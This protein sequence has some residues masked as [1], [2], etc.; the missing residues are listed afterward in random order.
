MKV[1]ILGGNAAGMSA[2]GRLKRKDPSVE[3]TVI[4]KT[5]EVSY[6]A[7]GLPFYVG[8]I[9]D[10]LDLM[11]IRKPEAFLAQ[12]IDLRLCEQAQAVD[13]SS[14]QVTIGKHGGSY[15]QAYDRL[16]IATGSSAIVPRIPGSTLE[17][18]YTLKTL[19]D[20]AA[21]KEALNKREA[22]RVVIIGGGYIGLE[23]AEACLRL[24][25][26]VCILEALNKLLNGFDEEFGQ[27]ACDELVR[28]GAAVH[29]G[30]AVTSIEADGHDRTV[31]TSNGSY[32]ADVVVFAI[33]VRPNTGFLD[34]S[35][36]ERLPNGAII[37]NCRM[38]TSIPG[39]YAA[40]D[41]AGVMHKLLKRS[42]Y[43]PLGTN[44]N[45]QGR[46]CG[47]AILGISTENYGGALGTAMLRCVTLELAKTGLSLAEA[48][49]AGIDA[50]AKIINAPSHAGYYL[51]PAPFSIT[52]KLCYERGTGRLLGAQLMGRGES[53]WRIN[54]FA[55]AIDQGMTVGQ[56]G[57]LDMGYAPPF[58]TV[59]D[60]VEIAAN[61]V[62][63]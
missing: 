44:A 37:T 3:V 2:A 25:K 18:V 36:P 49:Q 30:A 52:M 39:V 22:A 15:T 57:A 27:A 50:D 19:K 29:L 38:E 53:A 60:A 40:G 61:A 21:L 62:K 48:N 1:L 12:G 46:F 23:L 45:K 4:E 33:G 56:L 58:S 17:G 63:P 34:A 9:N 20:G 10:D 59:W 28:Q 43:L 35:G 26:K 5:Q 32:Q 11:R 14:R 24:G 41:C 6:G 13:F 51:A 31:H 42:V 55:C 16:L 47:D 7:C 8:G 54:V